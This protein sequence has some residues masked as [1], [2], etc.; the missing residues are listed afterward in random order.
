MADKETVRGNSRNQYAFRCDKRVWVFWERILPQI[1]YANKGITS[2]V[3]IDDAVAFACYCLDEYQD[4]PA[5][6]AAYNFRR[7]LWDAMTGFR[8]LGS[9]THEV[10]ERIDEHL[11]NRRVQQLYLEHC[12]RY[13]GKDGGAFDVP[14]SDYWTKRSR[15]HEFPSFPVYEGCSKIQHPLYS[16]LDLDNLRESAACTLIFKYMGFKEVTV[17]LAKGTNQ[18]LASYLGRFQMSAEEALLAILGT[19]QKF[20]PLNSVYSD[21]LRA[22]LFDRYLACKTFVLRWLD[23]LAIFESLAAEGDESGR[24][25]VE[26]LAIFNRRLQS[27]QS[28][29]DYMA[30]EP[31]PQEA[32]EADDPQIPTLDRHERLGGGG[33]L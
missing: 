15:A 6:P 29:L 9:F 22:D 18:S 16:H 23:Q 12:V 13:E 24:I 27:G 20:I 1:G 8:K 30:D 11:R 3:L 31:S 2:D 33:M 32:Q 28:L 19:F 26:R 5:H 21:S 10:S 7:C 4:F 17:S 14:S 25:I